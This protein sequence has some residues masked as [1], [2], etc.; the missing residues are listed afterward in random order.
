MEASIVKGTVAGGPLPIPPQAAE[1]AHGMG[2]TRSTYYN[3]WD[4][5]TTE[6]VA[7]VEAE[8]EKV[9]KLNELGTDGQPLNDAHKKDLEKR[10]A[11]KEAKKKWVS[12]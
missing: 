12:G 1:A 8:E 5:F 4:K 9:K 6:E 7:K 2:D 11:L 10:K 3:K